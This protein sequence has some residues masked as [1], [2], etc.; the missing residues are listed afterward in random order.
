MKEIAMQNVGF[1]LLFFLVELVNFLFL[2]LKKIIFFG[3]LCVTKKW[4]IF[5][6]ST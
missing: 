5:A 2:K 4:R 6:V 3:Y 1:V